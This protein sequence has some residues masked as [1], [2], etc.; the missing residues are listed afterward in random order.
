MGVVRE[1]PVMQLAPRMQERFVEGKEEEEL[2]QLMMVLLDFEVAGL[3]YQAR[4]PLSV[5]ERVAPTAQV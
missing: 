3:I 2:V 1:E 4:W 5:L